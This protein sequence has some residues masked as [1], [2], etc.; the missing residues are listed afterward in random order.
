MIEA[1]H[2]FGFSPVALRINLISALAS[3]RLVSSGSAS[4]NAATLTL[5]GL[6]LFSAI[7]PT[8]LL[9]SSGQPSACAWHPRFSFGRRHSSS[10]ACGA[11][12]RILVRRHSLADA[13]AF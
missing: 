9:P 7:P 8:G 3:A 5:V 12:S 6:V 2:I 10:G 11:A 4:T 1:P 13:R